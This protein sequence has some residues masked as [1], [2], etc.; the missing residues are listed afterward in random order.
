MTE[1][2]KNILAELK[3]MQAE[4]PE[5]RDLFWLK[6]DHYDEA[7]Q[8]RGVEFDEK[9]EQQC[10]KLVRAIDSFTAFIEKSFTPSAEEIAKEKARQKLRAEFPNF[11]DWNKEA[12]KALLEREMN[13]LL[14]SGGKVSDNT[15]GFSKS[16]IKEELQNL[17]VL[18][19]DNFSDEFLTFYN[20]L[21][22]TPATHNF[23]KF[24]VRNYL[25]EQGYDENLVDS[26]KRITQKKTPTKLKV[27]FPDGIEITDEYASK[28]LAETIKKIGAKKVSDLN[29][30]FNS[31][32]LISQD[33]DSL[34]VA[35][36]IE[37]GYYVNTH[38][39][40][41]IKKQQLDKISQY[42]GLDL[43]VEITER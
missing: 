11:D 28:T 25:L 26:L 4:L 20:S 14:K 13:E 2:I 27:S 21:D 12:K 30:I 24:S 15:I 7:E 19:G 16:K 3:A 34:R 5:L 36:F 31:A 38:S 23:Q 18:N 33:K 40:T 29:M 32:P 37:D 1:R 41:G 10:G 9:F 8:Q 39:P 42:L 17:T 43:K 22:P 35:T 6:I